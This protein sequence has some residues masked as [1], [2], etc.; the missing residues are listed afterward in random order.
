MTKR[1]ALVSCLMVE[2]PNETLIEK[3]LLDMDIDGDASYSAAAKDEITQAELNL[4]RVLVSLPDFTEG[5]LSVKHKVEARLL[6]IEKL[7]QPVGVP[8]IR[9][10]SHLW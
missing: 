6:Q 8:T 2:V 4:L 10:A 5:P 9:D 7:Q 1:E 3:V